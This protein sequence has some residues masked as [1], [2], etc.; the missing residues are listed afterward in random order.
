MTFLIIGNECNYKKKPDRLEAGET[1][2]SF[3]KEP[4]N[5]FLRIFY[6]KIY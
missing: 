3:S 5:H 1:L 4:D 6:S 2:P